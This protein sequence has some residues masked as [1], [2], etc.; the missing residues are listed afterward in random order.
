MLLEKK[1]AEWLLRVW[2][3]SLQSDYWNIND[4]NDFEL[5]FKSEN[6]VRTTTKLSHIIVED[7]SSVAKTYLVVVQTTTR[8]T[9]IVAPN[10][11]WVC[12]E[13][14]KNYAN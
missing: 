7:V 12:C 6:K 11:M 9:K 4:E 1:K 3:V 14:L 10:G 5:W 13:C 8:I 2:S